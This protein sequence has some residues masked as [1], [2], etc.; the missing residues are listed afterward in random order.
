M[1]FGAVGI[2]LDLGAQLADEHAQILR[3]LGM[4]RTPDGGQD[5][6]VGDDAAGVAE[7]DR[8]GDRIPSASA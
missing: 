3:V 1:I 5:L 4:R 6:A 8:A 2:A 7:E